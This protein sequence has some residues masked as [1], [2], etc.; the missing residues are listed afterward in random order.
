V[1]IRVDD[2]KD[3]P[4]LLRSEEPLETLPGL[5][6]VQESGDCE[7]LSPVTVE[8]T[9]AREYDHIRVKG[10]LSARIRLNCSRCLGDFE[11]DLASVFTI[12]FR[13]EDRVALDEEEVEL[14]EEDLISVTYQGDEIDFAPEIAEQV[15]MELP[16]KPLCHESCRGLCPVCGVDL[17]E[18]ECTCAGSSFSLK[19]SAL[20]DFKFD[21]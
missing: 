16:L 14:A 6:A 1:K 10:N 7:F 4:R 17:N 11:T 20:K 8:L 12:F 2:I 9:V 13:K 3:Q 21:K 19:F 5:T 18:Q 15:I